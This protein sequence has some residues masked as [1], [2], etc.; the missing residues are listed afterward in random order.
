[1]LRS[2][3]I[4]DKTV[5]KCDKYAKEN[6]LSRSAVIRLALNTFLREVS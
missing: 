2:V 5:E 1:M 4:D 6:G 3:N